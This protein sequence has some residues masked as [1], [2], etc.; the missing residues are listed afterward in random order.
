MVRSDA[1]SWDLGN[2]ARYD[3]SVKMKHKAFAD[4]SF[5]LSYA[6]FPSSSHTTSHRNRSGN[7]A[8]CTKY[9][10]TAKCPIRLSLT[11]L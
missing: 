7:W 3:C 9:V 2:I 1:Y 8:T 6:R 5:T 4:D 10:D 11:M